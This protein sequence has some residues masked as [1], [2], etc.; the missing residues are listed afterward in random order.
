MLMF[1]YHTPQN[2]RKSKVF[3]G[4]KNGALTLNWLHKN[5]INHKKMFLDIFGIIK[6]IILQKLISKNTVQL[7]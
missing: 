7:N 5:K 6:T 1:H 4:Y 3:R 2:V